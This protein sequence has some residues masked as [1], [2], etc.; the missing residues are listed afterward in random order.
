MCIKLATE[1]QTMKNY[2]ELSVFSNLY[3]CKFNVFTVGDKKR[4]V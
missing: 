3:C 1:K 2:K 4:G